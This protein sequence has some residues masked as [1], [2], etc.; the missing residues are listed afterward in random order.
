MNVKL[1]G[2][3]VF[4][5]AITV[6][7]LSADPTGQAGSGF[8]LQGSGSANSALRTQNP[9]PRTANTEPSTLNPE[10]QKAL[11]AKYCVTCHND[12]AKTGGLSLQKVNLDSV[13]EGAETWEKVVRKLRGGM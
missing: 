1:A 13:P 4:A 2:V 7:S 3:S 11:V 10:P 9:A 5:M 12:R 6:A 8:K